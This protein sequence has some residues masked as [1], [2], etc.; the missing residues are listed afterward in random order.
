[1][2]NKVIDNIHIVLVATTHPGNI[3]AAARA[4]K[5]MGIKNLRLV[6]PKIFPSADAS[7]RASGA[8]DI[9]ASAQLFDSLEQAIEGCSLVFASS[10]RTR[11]ISWPVCTPEQTAEQTLKHTRQGQQVAI[12]FGRESSGM[13]NDEMDCC[14][15]MLQIATNADFSSLNL[16]SAVQIICYEIRK[17][18]PG[19]DDEKREDERKL[20]T[21]EQMMQFYQHLETVLIE[22][23]YLHPENPRRLMRRLKRLFNRTQLDANEYNILR[24]VLAAVAEKTKQ[25]RH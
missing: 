5:T 7:A 13:T 8:D 16:A 9:L 12:V 11:S 3:G 25:L 23:G 18:M 20:A 4:M 15:A 19:D 21:A 14:N 22:I 24:G 1:M 2:N 17:L 10:A 6:A